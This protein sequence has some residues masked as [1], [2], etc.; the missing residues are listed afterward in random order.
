MYT[1]IL[2]RIK[3]AQQAK[4]TML[5]V[6]FSNMDMAILEL[7]KKHGYIEDAQKRG[8]MPKRVIEIKPKYEKEEGKIQ[9][10]SFISK[11]SRSLFGGYRALSRFRRHFGFLAIST[12]KGIMSLPE[13]RKE[14]VG[15]E[16][17]FEIW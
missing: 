12:P 16:A 5:K 10:V 15:G 17:L 7:L 4:K 1:D 3:N 14:K 2:I 9:G 6:P 11:P 13:A 8:R